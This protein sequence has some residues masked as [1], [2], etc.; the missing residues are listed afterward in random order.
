MAR[1]A[2]SGM[3]TS[4]PDRTSSP[5]ASRMAVR[6]RAFWFARPPGPFSA[7]VIRR[8][9]LMMVRSLYE[10]VLALFV[11]ASYLHESQLLR[12]ADSLIQGDLH[13]QGIDRRPG[14]RGDRA[15]GT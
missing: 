5:Q 12:R 8:P 10:S 14:R 3:V 15:A 2:T 6:V 13:D 9:P 1:A 7:V 4:A 11:M